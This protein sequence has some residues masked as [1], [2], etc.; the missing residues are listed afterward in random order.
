MPKAVQDRAIRQQKEVWAWYQGLNIGEPTR[1]AGC[2]PTDFPNSLGPPAPAVEARVIGYHVVV[3]VR[4]K[5]LPR[6]LACRPRT[7]SIA[8]RGMS[9]HPSV[10]AIPWVERYELQGRV[11]RAVIRLPMYSAA[12]YELDLVSETIQ[13]RRSKSVEMVLSCPSGGC[14]AGE[15]PPPHQKSTLRKFPLR[16]VSRSQLEASFREGIDA[17]GRTS[18]YMQHTVSCR[19]QTVCQATFTDPL[20]PREPL[21]VRYAIGGEQIAKCWAVT[22]WKYLDELPYEDMPRPSPSAGCVAWPG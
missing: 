10:R 6:A 14:V 1:E 18:P 2:R 9:I 19:S 16:E 20:F 3:V 11:G 4:F 15:A 17:A 13:G 22:D 8:I 21:R 7:L 5:T 12:P